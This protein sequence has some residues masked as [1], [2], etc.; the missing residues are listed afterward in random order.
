M[1]GKR[2]VGALGV[3]CAVAPGLAGCGGR[4]RPLSGSV[5]GIVASV[6]QPLLGAWGRRFEQRSGVRVQVR[7]AKLAQLAPSV[8]DFALEDG[9]PL[10]AGVKDALVA[11]PVARAE[12]AIAY[13]LVTFSNKRIPSGFRIDPHTLAS[14]YKGPTFNWHQKVFVRLNPHVDIPDE[15]FQVCR[16]SGTWAATA[17]F[18]AFLARSGPNWARDVGIGAHVKWPHLAAPAVETTDVAGC[19]KRSSGSIGYVTPAEAL[20]LGL[21]VAAVQEA[22]GNFLLPGQAGYP[23]GGSLNVLVWRDPCRAGRTRQAAANVKAW[24]D[25]MLGAGQGLVRRG[26]YE[27]LPAAARTQARRTVAGLTCHGHPIAVPS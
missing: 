22:G 8:A 25:F 19:V 11:V 5:T 24:L 7:L 20:R 14:V 16:N 4:D 23:I 27:P 9:T 10:P 15:L 6:P 21:T 17:T 3:V 18:T 1:W 26:G 12:V 13:N 2:S